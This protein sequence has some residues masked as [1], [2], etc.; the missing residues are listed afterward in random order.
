MPIEVFDAAAPDAVYDFLDERIGRRGRDHWAW[1]YRFHDSSQPN[2]FY[3]RGDDGAVLGFIGMMRT[4]LHGADGASW[5]AAWFV[6]W[7]VIP[8]DRG[9]GVGMG[10]LRK[11]EAAAGILLTL[12]GSEDTRKMLPRLGWKESL[13]PATWVRPL[14]GHYV[15]DWTRRRGSRD[16]GAPIV[17]VA[18]AAALSLMEWRHTNSA[19]F[20]FRN[21]E[22]VPEQHDEVWQRR[23]A[24]LAP[25]MTRD[26]LCLDWFCCRYPGRGYRITMLENYGAPAGHLVTRIDR[27]AGGMLRGRIVDLVWPHA[28]PQW[29]EDGLALACRQL[30]EGGADYVQCVSSRP[31]LDVALGNQYFRRRKLV[32]LW[33]HRLPD[34]APHPDSWLVSLLD[35]D[36]AYR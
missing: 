14:S 25:L 3:W 34:G 13:R 5:P 2:A 8:G 9:V 33:Y 35:C 32:P 30:R 18:A 6:D 7:Q 4:R 12:Q 31:E 22:S 28:Q 29:L 26:R 23:S 1:K 36:R 11:A 15:A 20:G 10:L 19:S 27:D 21:V 24:E 17:M 16:I